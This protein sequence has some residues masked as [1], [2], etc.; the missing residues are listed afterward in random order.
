MIATRDEAFLEIHAM[1]QAHIDVLMQ[2]Y[3]YLT[4]ISKGGVSDNDIID[5]LNELFN[6]RH[7]HDSRDKND[8]IK[9][10]KTEY[11]P[12]LMTNIKS[13]CNVY[14][15]MK[16][17]AADPNE[18]AAKSTLA[19]A[20][21]Y[22]LFYADLDQKAL[23]K[24]PTMAVRILTAMHGI[25]FLKSTSESLSRL[26]PTLH[27]DMH[28]CIAFE[29]KTKKGSPA[30]ASFSYHWNSL[31]H[32]T[33]ELV[34]K[35]MNGSQRHPTFKE[36]MGD[37]SQTNQIEGWSEYID[38]FIR[39][40][41]S[42]NAEDAERCIMQSPIIEQR[43]TEQAR[44]VTAYINETKST[45][46]P[47]DKLLDFLLDNVKLFYHIYPTIQ[48]QEYYLSQVF[49]ISSAVR[50]ETRRIHE[51]KVR[52]DAMSAKV[53]GEMR[54]LHDEIHSL[55]VS[56]QLKSMESDDITRYTLNV[57]DAMRDCTQHAKILSHPFTLTTD[58]QQ[59]EATMTE[60]QRCYKDVV[61]SVSDFKKAL[62]HCVHAEQLAA[63][64]KTEELLRNQQLA[65]DALLA[66]AKRKNQEYRDSI[67]NARKEKEA[68]LLKSKPIAQAVAPAV[69][70][71]KNVTMEARL[72][73]LNKDGIAVLTALFNF[74]KDVHYADVCRVITEQLGGSIKEV[75]NGSSHKRIIL[76]KYLIE[77]T[78]HE[79]FE[80]E[81][82]VAQHSH[83]TGGFF[84]QH[85]GAHH[86]GVMVR[87]NMELV[88]TTLT[89]AGITLDV[90][91]RLT[92]SNDCKN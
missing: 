54:D 17:I 49:N 24:H 32:R 22:E 72:C 73:H 40:I 78:A 50:K 36:V 64:E 77:L 6:L 13:R 86:A 82:A 14:L 59:V 3:K 70:L 58:I 83:A 89:K 30:F 76:D 23:K 26:L 43:L 67:E 7:K 38:Q 33:I 41:T 16:Q 53:N 92:A 75:G 66:A 84:K 52:F 46:K 55:S 80:A 31:H 69:T 35:M 19:L 21:Q 39:K 47:N 5:Y 15:K 56:T 68:S 42:A 74:E 71:F 18:D 62:D 65:R 87:F 29:S 90:L 34:G 37:H 48:Q 85:K 81:K 91:Q 60:Y 79:G 25:D 4:L 27:A 63:A 61:A 28:R 57:L 88:V 44:L 9:K 12:V 1:L 20:L 11:L 45:D 8:V 2:H 51:L 10:F